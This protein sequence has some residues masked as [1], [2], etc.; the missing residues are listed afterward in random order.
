MPLL[1][2]LSSHKLAKIADVLEVVSD[3]KY[4]YTIV[5]LLKS[6]KYIQYL[7][8]YIYTLQ[9]Q[10]FYKSHTHHIYNGQKHIYLIIT[11]VY[12]HILYK[13]SR[14]RPVSHK[15]LMF[16]SLRSSDAIYHR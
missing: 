14:E 15:I 5:Y 9:P 12:I 8:I 7:Y 13:I 16:N 4:T 2:D 3:Q 6:H 10:L 11:G 1:R